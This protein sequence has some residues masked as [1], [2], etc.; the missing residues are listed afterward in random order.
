M[1]WKELAKSL[2]KVANASEPAGNYRHA[3]IVASER[4]RELLEALARVCDR[5]DEKEKA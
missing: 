3:Y 2:R 1:N 4:N 5:M